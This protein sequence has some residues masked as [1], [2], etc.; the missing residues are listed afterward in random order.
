MKF[1]LLSI[2]TLIHVVGYHSGSVSL[3]LYSAINHFVF[4]L[5]V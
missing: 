1:T 5:K 3:D 2:L 4:C